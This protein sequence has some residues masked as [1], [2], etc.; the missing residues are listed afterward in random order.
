MPPD[1]AHRTSPSIATRHILIKVAAGVDESEFVGRAEAIGLR[2]LKRLGTTNWYTMALPPGTLATPRDMAVAAGRLSGV[3]AA[4]ADPILQ[5][6]DIIPPT[7]P[8]YVDDPDPGT[9]CD[10]VSDS[11]CSPEDLVDQWGLFQVEAAVV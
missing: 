8:F 6:A 11:S 5:I 2:M 10:I 3:T 7:D 4:V 1:G 9:D